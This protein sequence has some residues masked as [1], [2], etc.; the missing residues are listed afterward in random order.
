L[1]NKVFGPGMCEYYGPYIGCVTF[2]SLFAIVED[3]YWEIDKQLI[4]LVKQKKEFK[5][6]FS[7]YEGQ[8]VGLPYN[9]PFVLRKK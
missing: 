1:V 3:D 9:I 2:F 5:L 6:D 4:K 8:I 7:K